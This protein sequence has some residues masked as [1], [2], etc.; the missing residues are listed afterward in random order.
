MIGLLP[1]SNNGFGIFNDF[2]IFVYPYHHKEL[3]LSLNKT[4]ISFIYN[5]I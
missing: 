5:V 3:L 4:I 2:Q 1:I